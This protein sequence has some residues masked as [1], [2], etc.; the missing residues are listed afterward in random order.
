M[1]VAEGRKT[2]LIDRDGVINLD[3]MDYVM[4]WEDF[5]FLPG[6]LD[7][8]RRLRE[9]GFAIAVISNQAGVG[10]GVFGKET[11]DDITEKMCDAVR[12]SGGSIDGVFYCLHGKRGNCNCR[13]P[14]TGLFEQAHRKFGF[15]PA[16]TFFIGDKLSDIK[17]GKD[18]GA[19]T[20]MVLTGYGEKHRGEITPETRP[21]FIVPDFEAAVGKVLEGL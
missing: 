10:D 1:T 11:L 16:E 18:F 5:K 13:K 12:L 19:R 2:V 14:R 8:L 20:I 15:R 7:G 6:V 9:K 17:A 4:K 3:L 21:D